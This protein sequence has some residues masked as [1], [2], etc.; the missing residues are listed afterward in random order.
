[1]SDTLQGFELIPDLDQN[2]RDRARIVVASNAHDVDDARLLLDT[3]G[4]LCTPVEKPV[5]KRKAS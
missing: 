4:L 1:M 2:A 5:E 3:L